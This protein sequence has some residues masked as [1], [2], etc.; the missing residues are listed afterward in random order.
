MTV[1]VFPPYAMPREE[2]L[3]KRI[4]IFTDCD[5]RISESERQSVLDPGI[6]INI[7]Y[8][9][10]ILHIVLLCF[11]IVIILSVINGFI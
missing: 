10:Y 3:S 2:Y 1:M 9:P 6:M 11:F 7:P 8:V 4:S 5:R